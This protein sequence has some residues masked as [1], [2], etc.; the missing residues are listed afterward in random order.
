MYILK[1]NHF[2]CVFMLFIKFDG[3]SEIRI[4]LFKLSLITVPEALCSLRTIKR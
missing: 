1:H 2:D 3:K 4:E